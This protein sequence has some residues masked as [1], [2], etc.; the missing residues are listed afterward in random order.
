VE[1]QGM[2]ACPCAQEL[3]MERSQERLKDD[4]FS[5]DEI[6]R[7]RKMILATAHAGKAETPDGPIVH[8]ARVASA[9]TRPGDRTG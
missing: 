2:T 7:V 4:G 3:V 1:A 6:A 8:D 9:R 5:D